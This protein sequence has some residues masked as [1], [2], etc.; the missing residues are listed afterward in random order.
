MSCILEPLRALS[1]RCARA[2]SGDDAGF[3]I[4]EVM[5]ALAIFALV[6]AG[7]VAGAIGGS[8]ASSSAKNQVAS[9]NVAQN[10]LEQARANP[11]PAPTSY[12]TAPV[13]NG[14]TYS[15]TRTVTTVAP[16]GAAAGSCPAGGE[17]HISVLVRANGT[18]NASRLDTVV[19]C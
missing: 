14:P 11:T 7:A 19:A 4:I 17:R 13:A 15:V 16:A 2:R 5:V 8:K 6:A 3:T 12:S 9:V 10:D 18:N 1:R